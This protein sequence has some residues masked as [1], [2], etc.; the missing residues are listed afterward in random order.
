VTGANVLPRSKQTVAIVA[1]TLASVFAR[2]SSLAGQVVVGVYLTEAQV[3][4]YAI[5]IGVLGVTALMRGGGAALYLPTIKPEDFEAKASRLFWWCTGFL[6]FS[7][8]LTTAVI[9]L[10][11]VVQESE[12]LLAVL[13]GLARASDLPGLEATLWLLAIRQIIISG[14]LTVG[15]M[16]M[17]VELRFQELA[18]LDTILAL[19]RLA[20][21][22]VAA[23][24]GLGALA[25]AL[26][27]LAVSV[28]ELM[29]YFVSN[30][31]RLSDLRWNG[32]GF[33][34]LA[35]NMRWPLVTAIA[36]SLNTQVN[37]LVLGI[38]IPASTL[39]VFY[40][41]F[42]LASQPTFFLA[43]ALQNVL[44]P[45]LA[46]DRGNPVLERQGM[47]RVFAAG[48]LYVPITTVATASFFPSLERLLWG[49]RWSAASSGIMFLCIGATYMTVAT[50]LTGPLLGLRQFKAV[51]AFEAG[52]IFGTVG[53]AALGALLI[54][55]PEKLLPEG[56]SP[57]T[58]VCAS[59]GLTMT[60]ASLAQLVWIMRKYGTEWQSLL[61][62]LSFGPMLALLTAVA[63]QSVG[64][65]LVTTLALPD[66]RFSA[67]VELA[68]VCGVYGALILMAIRFTAEPTLRDTISV[69]PAGLRD[70]MNRLLALA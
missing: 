43:T 41:A 8:V 34:E 4:T 17:S 25:L 3:G 35:A 22:W 63:S 59:T 49:G 28:V 9:A 5:A 46:R 47:E 19:L 10:V 14:P 42:Q 26:P 68:A 50:I 23:A 20:L 66:G 31:C 67:A 58:A 12:W 38:L 2:L 48:M 60:A 36:I 24:S 44:A 55:R 32:S 29:Y 16:R 52:K 45:F 51:A 64:H 18:K 61:R 37:L 1:M 62:M 15:R 11:P 70:R 21:T 69:L 54:W 40:F 56:V 27:P 30:A 6:T 57:E 53:G 65:S 39:G 33:R 7:A 13:P